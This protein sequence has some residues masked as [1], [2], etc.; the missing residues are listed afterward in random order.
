MPV[1]TQATLDAAT[2]AVTQS[3]DN[4]GTP[5]V[6]GAFFLKSTSA[7]TPVWK[8]Q[9]RPRGQSN[10]IDIPWVNLSTFTLVAAGNFAA[11]DST[12]YLIG[13]P[14]TSAFDNFRLYLVSIVSGSY[15][16]V[17]Y[18]YSPEETVEKSFPLNIISST[19]ANTI[20]STSANALAVGRQ[21]ATN[22]VL[23]INANT[24]SVVT[25]ITLT[26]AAAG[27]GMDITV[28]SSGTNENL[29]INAKG[30]GT[31]TL[32]PTGTGSVV[33]GQDLTMTDA[34]N[35][36]VNSSTGTKIGTA[37]TQKIGF[38]NATPAVQPVANTDTTTGAAGST[39]TVF[40]NTTF[41]GGGTAAYTIGG[42]VKSLKAL[43]LLAA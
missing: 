24:A 26:G 14:D 38:F 16:G 4:G 15:A 9:G 23:N 36:V 12:D 19:V 40:L 22:P 37:T 29:T 2:E 11:T 3:T 1:S 34:K 28:T 41:T 25:G 6:S 18:G 31:I 21:G 8:V 20:T 13:V 30:S 10:Y 39:T 5:I 43:G 7:T 32:N 17:S 27:A 42:V 35:I 33:I